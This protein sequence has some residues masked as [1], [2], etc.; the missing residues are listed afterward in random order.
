MIRDSVRCCGH[1]RQD[2]SIEGTPDYIRKNWRD[3]WELN[4]VNFGVTDG[5]R[6]RTSWA[7]TRRAELLHHGHRIFTIL[8]AKMRTR[9]MTIS[10]YHFALLHF[11]D[12]YFRRQTGQRYRA[13]LIQLY[14]PI[15][16][17]EIHYP[18]RILLSTVRTRHILCLTKDLRYPQTVLLPI[19]EEPFLVPSIVIATVPS[20]TLDTR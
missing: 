20:A 19:I 10:A 14:R 1:N 11:F 16:M 3:R 18:I 13:K 5:F 17:V 12:Q 2:G 15:Q 9:S 4:L 8:P 6:P 7:T